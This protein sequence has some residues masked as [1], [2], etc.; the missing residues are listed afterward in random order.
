MRRLA[1]ALCL[2]LLSAACAEDDSG[3]GDGAANAER[4]P[5]YVVAPFSKLPSVAKPI[6]LGAR[7]AASEINEQGGID[8]K[9]TKALLDIRLA[10]DEGSPSAAAA[11]IR[12][13]I[14]DGAVA[15]VAE[16]TGVDV[17]WDDANRAG[18]PIGIVYQGGEDLVDEQARP[19]VF[20]IAPTNRGIAFRLAEYLIP[21][22]L[23]IA[24]LHDD[25]PYGA[26]GKEALDRAFARNRDSVAGEYRLSS[27][28]GADPAAQVLQA[29]QAGATAL[30]VWALP[31]VVASVVRATRST[32]WDV[33]IYTSTTGGDPLVRQQLASQ[34]SWV[35]GL[36]FVSSRLTSEKGP[37]PFE[38]YRAAFE[39]EFGP[40]KVGVRTADGREVVAPPEW[41][42]YSYDFVRVVADAVARS[43]SLS[44]SQEL[45]AAMEET[46]VQGANGDERGFNKKNHEGV[47]DDDIFFAEFHG[48]VWRPVEDD[49]LSAS[50]PPIPQTV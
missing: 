13:A 16:G 37:A 46:E 17:A 2:L 33:P 15:I 39:E 14:A 28:P 50:L 4:L 24:L 21:K 20:R 44:P 36:T 11:A 45:V 32:G 34:P 18:V 41:S 35:D 6:E 22:G 38:R 3:D 49:P 8:V 26:A 7:L 10:D 19:N 12:R 25:S 1:L 9:G 47:V 43:E 48:M 40:Q 29:R 5:V 42:M 30:L 31:S 23:K 27:A